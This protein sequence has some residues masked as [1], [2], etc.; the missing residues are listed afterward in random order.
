[1]GYTGC[2]LAPLYDLPESHVPRPERG[3]LLRVYEDEGQLRVLKIYRRRRSIRREL[4]AGLSHAL[5][6]RK[7][8][9]RPHQRRETEREGLTLWASEGFDVPA[10]FDAAPPVSAA[11]QPVLWLEFLRG[12]R[13]FELVRDTRVS[14]TEKE[15]LVARLARSQALRHR[16]ALELNQP[17]LVHEHPT[18][19]HVLVVGSRLVTI[20]L[21]GAYAPSYPVLY[22]V[23][24]ELAGFLRSLWRERG[25]ACFLDPLSRAF[26]RGYADSR[27]LEDACGSYF[28]GGLISRWHVASD[29]RRRGACSKSEVMAQLRQHL[30]ELPAPEAVQNQT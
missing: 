12:R 25:Q 26:V 2:V 18:A 5:F 23:A 16:R 24:R 9:V 22:A 13:L 10:I 28:G 4:F 27:L 21:E 14:E 29:R 17:L 19:K 15:R 20:D 1:M 8:G 7:R 11:G 6:E 3:N 30:H